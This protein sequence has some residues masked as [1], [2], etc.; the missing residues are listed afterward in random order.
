MLERVENQH[1]TRELTT[2]PLP[3]KEFPPGFSVRDLIVPLQ[4]NPAASR[5]FFIK[6]FPRLR[7]GFIVVQRPIF[8]HRFSLFLSWKGWNFSRHFA[9]GFVVPPKNSRLVISIILRK[10][11]A[12]IFMAGG[13]DI[14]VIFLV[15]GKN[16]LKNIL[17][18]SSGSCGSRYCT[19]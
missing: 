1:N 6:K 11:R 12:G 10:N 3:L 15:T 2:N 19:T 9:A 7:R 16:E 8:Y 5:R 13:R 4:K 14:N 18:D 17:E